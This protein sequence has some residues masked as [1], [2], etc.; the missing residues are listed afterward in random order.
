MRNLIKFIAFLLL[1]IP[2]VTLWSL[3]N[4][5]NTKNS[6]ISQYK[7]TWVKFINQVDL[8]EKK[9][10]NNE[11]GRK[12]ILVIISKIKIN[13]KNRYLIEYLKLSFEKKESTQTTINSESF[14]KTCFNW[15][16]PADISE[17]VIK[18]LDSSFEENFSISIWKWEI[19]YVCDS[20]WNDLNN[21]LSKD[22]PFKTAEKWLTTI[23]NF[24][25][26][27]S[28]LFCQWWDFS[29]SKSVRIDNI[30]CKAWDPCIIW[31]YNTN[32]NNIKKPIIRV[33][34]DQ[35]IK[36]IN[37]EN[38]WSA[39]KEEG[40]IIQNLHLIWN[41]S[42][43]W[44]FLYNKVDDVTIKNMIIENFWI[45]IQIWGSNW[46]SNWNREHSNNIKIK[47]NIIKDNTEQWILWWADNLNLEN[48][49]FINNGFWRPTFTHNIYLSAPIS[50]K[51][52][53][54]VTVKN[55]ISANST[56]YKNEW[57][58]WTS[59]VVHGRINNLQI[60]WNLV[61]EI[62]NTAKAWCWGISVDPAYWE[63]EYFNKLSIRNNTVMN[64]WNVAIWTASSKDVIIEDNDIYYW[65]SKFWW[66]RAIAV[67]VRTKWFEDNASENIN[68][69]DNIITFKNNSSNKSIYVNINDDVT[70]YFNVNDN[71]TIYKNSESEGCNVFL[72]TDTLKF[73]ESWNSCLK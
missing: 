33:S 20:N 47:N 46:D 23:R 53:T 52:V 35:A 48:S 70:W 22:K 13:S 30:N 62:E 37:L 45:W 32:S 14:T 67:P 12:K 51:D 31:D 59:L 57:C 55:N 17:S 11:K 19:Y 39:R 69:K 41:K 24:K 9:Y 15:N 36:V 6:I 10:S 5:N 7:S 65:D 68:I 3:E 1:F 2:V 38:W 25:S 58:D 40:F 42:W 29:I 27:N 16:I 4:I 71:H 28:V 26:W 66:I 63:K 72:N 8:L 34:W 54:N 64:L 73:S 43:N 60:E 44:F 56:N 18:S 50:W 61:Y 49:C 21:W